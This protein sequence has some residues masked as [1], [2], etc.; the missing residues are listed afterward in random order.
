MVMLLGLAR[1][2]RTARQI[3]NVSL[4]LTRLLDALQLRVGAR[5][6][7]L[8][9]H[10][11]SDTFQDSETDSATIREKYHYFTIFIR[12]PP[13]YCLVYLAHVSQLGRKAQFYEEPICFHAAMWR[14][15]LSLRSR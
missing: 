3:E 10:C 2:T 14:S 6:A 15:Q 12:S 8:R 4:D 5:A 11:N 9:Q 7:D 13:P 1:W